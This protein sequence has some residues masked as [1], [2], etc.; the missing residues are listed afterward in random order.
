MTIRTSQN[1]GVEGS[2]AVPL[3]LEIAYLPNMGSM[4]CHGILPIPP[5]AI[6]GVPVV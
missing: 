6:C 2:F 3:I 1:S 5:F 4:V